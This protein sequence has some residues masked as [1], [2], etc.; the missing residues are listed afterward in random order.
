VEITFGFHKIWRVSQPA[1][2]VLY[3][4]EGFCSMDFVTYRNLKKHIEQ[5]D[6]L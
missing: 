1:G 3:S 4:H 6:V 2:E 5:N